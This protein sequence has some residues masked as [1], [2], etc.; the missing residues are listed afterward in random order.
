VNNK[1]ANIEELLKQM[2]LDEKASLCSGMNRWKTE[3][4][5]RLGIASMNV[6]DGPHGVRRPK[7]ENEYGMKNAKENAPA[8]CFPTASALASSW[9][10]EL[11]KRIGEALAKEAKRLDVQIL[12]GPGINMKRSPLGGRNFEYY[13]EDPYLAGE[14]GVAYV[15]GLQSQGVGACV[16]HY[17]CN[18]QEH[19]RMSISAA[20]DERTLREIYLPAFE[21]IV[22]EAKP[23]SMMAA[24]NKVNGIYATENDYLLQSILREEWGFQGIVMSDWGATSQRVQA[25]AAGLDLEM[26]GP[27]PA[28]DKKIVAVVQEGKLD[29]QLLDQAV[30]NML[31][32]LFQVLEHRDPECEVDID[33]HHQLAKEAAVS[34]MV[35]LK[36]EDSILPLNV[37]RMSTLA[38]IGPMAVEPRYQGAGSSKVNATKL[39][40]PL[41]YIKKAAGDAVN[42]LYAQGYSDKL[43]TEEVESTETVL[44]G[45]VHETALVSCEEAYE[46]ELTSNEETRKTKLALRKEALDAAQ[47]ANVVLLFL[48]LPEKIESEGYDRQHID[49]P[50]NQ[51][52]LLEELAQVNENIV[53]VLNNGSAIAM[54]WIDK[55]KAV[56]EGWLCGQA[57]GSA[58]ADLLF[59]VINPSGKLQETFALQLEDNPSYLFFPGEEGKVEYREGIY[60]GYRYYDSKNMKVLFP[61]GHGLSY[62][63]FQYSNLQVSDLEIKDIDGL[64]AQVDVVNTGDRVGKEIVQL[65]VKPPRSRLKRP[66]KELKGFQKVE[67][68]PG[69]RKTVSFELTKRDFSYYDPN[70]G[71]WVMESGEYEIHIGK[72]SRE[73]CLSQVVTVHS[74]DKALVSLSSDSIVKEWIDSP[75][76]KQ[77]LFDILE[78]EN[79]KE[80]I[81]A[82]LAGVHAEMVLGMPIKKL[83]YFDPSKAERLDLILERLIQRLD[84]LRS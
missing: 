7:N 31:T 30:R 57:C 46:A 13:S 74:T 51:V 11:M 83:F 62:T 79:M 40:Q 67:L 36:N 54:P 64:Q 3:A 26:P 38:V 14:L 19:E 73:L 8:T 61:F 43:E 53:V 52:K 50:I 16:K 78:E 24:Y 72:S 48:G 6:S 70:V 35:L 29:E 58:I 75:I 80:K 21:K 15:N 17:A 55:A 23:W 41:E 2:T 37:S 45:T 25:L 49:L 66:I 10:R 4:I 76:G 5:D 84:V 34:S 42:V 56:L 33:A 47:K 44:R 68:S 60:I 18:N 9:D 28:N 81:D 32:V 69:E 12:L 39:E 20:V 77:A 63:T 27:S 71:A 65:Y 22:K 82:S 59:G 1:I